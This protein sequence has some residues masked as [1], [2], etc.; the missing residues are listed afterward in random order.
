MAA[1]I[2]PRSYGE[3]R[4]KA[5]AAA[6]HPHVERWLAR[7]LAQAPPRAKSLVVTILGDAIVP[8]GGEVWLSGLIDLLAP[9]G[10]DHRLTR[11]SVFRLTREGWLASRRV[12][13]RSLYALTASG[14][15][16]FEHAYRRVYTLPD[17][18]WNG[19]W[20]LVALPQ[21]LNGTVRAELR[22]ELA[23]EGFSMI[24]PGILGHP[25]ADPAT[26]DDILRSLG[27]Q[28]KVLVMSARDHENVGARSMRGLVEHSWDLK[29]L[30]GDYR[31]FIKR[32]QPVS[33]FFREHPAPSP[34][35][36]FIA[37]T[38]LIHSF[39]RVILHDPQ[40][41]PE[42]LPKDWPGRVAYDLCRELYRLTY[43]RAE[44]YLMSKL[45]GPRGKLPEASPA[46]Y[47]RFGGLAPWR[48][49]ARVAD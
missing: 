21:A 11:T 16:R 5:I 40:F 15:R 25:S 20:T 8:H 44:S 41:P 4:A 32:F 29:Q 1:R 10:V 24:A 18:P 48:R 7:Y 13:R 19:T 39:R 42:L 34:E 28:R 23:W 9:F 31:R 14:L 17:Q 36:A 46:F 6:S 47:R 12:G 26:L 30:A 22:K 2:N 35:Q 38:L 49:D 37:R 27:V 33:R 3:P 43:Q 45:E